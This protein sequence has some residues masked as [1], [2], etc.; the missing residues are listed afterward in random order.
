MVMKNLE[1]YIEITLGIS[2]GKPRIV[3][4]AEQIWNPENLSRETS[5]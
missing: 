2:G 3:K 4:L 5:I 1:Q